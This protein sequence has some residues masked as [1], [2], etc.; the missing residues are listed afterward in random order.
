MIINKIESIL[1]EKKITK[2]QLAKRLNIKRQSVSSQLSY[3]NS[4]GSPTIKTLKQW[5]EA[6]EIDFSILM[7]EF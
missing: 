7:N 3:W 4:G 1:K 5:S 2:S 6:L